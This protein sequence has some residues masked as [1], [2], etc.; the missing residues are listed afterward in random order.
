MRRSAD[1]LSPGW[2]LAAVIAAL[3]VALAASPPLL[4]FEAG[5][6]VYEGFAPFCHQIADRSPHAHGV[7]FALC[8]RCFGI[9]AGLAAGV[10]AG[11]LLPGV[12][13]TLAP[14]HPLTVLTL[15]ALPTATDWLL[16]VSGVLANTAASRLATGAIFGVTAG[17]LLAVAFCAPR[18]A[19]PSPH[20]S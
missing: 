1:L 4:G 12:L 3:V 8:H 13:R 10:A 14:R 20:P 19:I 5:A 18:R 9:V 11:P 15:A 16:G 17:L 7:P 2:A 6:L